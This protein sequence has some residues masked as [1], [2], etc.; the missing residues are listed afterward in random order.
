MERFRLT[1]SDL[2]LGE[3]EVGHLGLTFGACHGFPK[4][5]LAYHASADRDGPIRHYDMPTETM[6]ELLG[7]RVG[8]AD[9]PGQAPFPSA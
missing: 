9:A 6:S 7:V 5:A 1:G 2:L 4:C 3:Q 8:P